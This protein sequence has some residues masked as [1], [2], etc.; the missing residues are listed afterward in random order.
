MSAN[1]SAVKSSSANSGPSA[2]RTRISS[3]PCGCTL[4]ANAAVSTGTSGTPTG[5]STH[6]SSRE[7]TP[8]PPPT[9][10]RPLLSHAP[11]P[12]FANRISFSLV[13]TGTRTARRPRSRPPGP[14]S[15]RRCS[16]GMLAD[17]LDLVALDRE[18]QPD[19][20]LAHT[21]HASPPRTL[22]PTVP[23]HP[24]IEPSGPPRS[25]TCSPR[26]AVPPT[27][28]ISARSPGPTHPRPP[29][30]PAQPAQPAVQPRSTRVRG[31]TTNHKILPETPLEEHALQ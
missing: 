29:R 23:T 22:P 31:S 11:N 3:V 21:C 13:P 7:R 12:D 25:L 6:R 28:P 27:H 24:G 10:G 1:S 16:R 2:S 8:V 4:R 30:R 20:L 17:L 26:S 5:R 18:K 14:P 15:R 19:Q 9:S